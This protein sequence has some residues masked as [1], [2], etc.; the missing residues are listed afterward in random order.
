MHR[1]RKVTL[2]NLKYNYM[3]QNIYH[4]STEIWRQFHK[5]YP[6]SQK[7]TVLVNHKHEY[8]KHVFE[9][10]K[11]MYI[12]LF[13]NLLRWYRHLISSLLE[14]DRNWENNHHIFGKQWSSTQQ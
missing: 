2:S 7:R 11:Q 9:N 14:N 1:N 12:I 13:L 4:I 10:I 5:T 8:Y 6:S 3:K